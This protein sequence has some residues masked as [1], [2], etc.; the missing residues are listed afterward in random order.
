[1]ATILITHGIPKEGFHLL[2]EHRVIMP[3]PLGAF[4]E[5][6]L[7]HHVQYADA[8]VAGGRVSGDVIRAGKSLKIIANYGAGYDGVDTLTARQAGVMVTNIPDSVTSD[9]AE[10]TLGLMLA[11]A[12]RIGK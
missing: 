9:T 6:E 3:P 12:R 1:M 8:I 7:M 4:T 2:E 10:L 5:E 11:A